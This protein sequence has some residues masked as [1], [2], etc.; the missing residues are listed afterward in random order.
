MFLSHC[1]VIFPFQFHQNTV[2]CL[3]F[4]NKK[5]KFGFLGPPFLFNQ[6]YDSQ[7]MQVLPLFKQDH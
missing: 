1:I 2:F 6:E 3:I 4:K 7:F 5:L